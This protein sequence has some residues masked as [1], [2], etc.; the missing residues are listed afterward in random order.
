MNSEQTNPADANLSRQTRGQKSLQDV[1]T[2]RLLLLK[3]L[4]PFILLAV[5][6]FV[7][8]NGL[9]LLFFDLSGQK[10]SFLDFLLL[11]S[12][13][14]LSLSLLLGLFISSRR[15]AALRQI[16]LFVQRF[17][18]GETGAS[19]LI[20]RTDEMEAL[21]N[22]LNQMTAN[23]Q[24]KIETLSSDKA[25][26]VAILSGM[27]EGVMVLD[28]RGEVVLTNASFEKMFGLSSTDL[29][30]RHYYEHLRHHTLNE[31][32]K[33]VIHT[34][35]SLSRAIALEGPPPQYF[36]VQASVADFAPHH[37]VALVFHDITENKRQEQIQKDFVANVSHELRTPISL[38]KGYVETLSDGTVVDPKQAKS[39]LDIIEK[40]STRLENIILDLLQ[41]SRI[42]SGLDPV[43]LRKISLLDCIQKNI[44]LL[45]PLVRKKN[46]R[47]TVSVPTNLQI[48]VDPEKLDQ[49]LTNIID[50]AIKYTPE[51]GEIKIHA[52]E[53]QNNIRIR[54]E[55][56]GIG[57][58]KNEHARIFERFYRVDQTRS[59][60]LGGTG[61]GLAIVKQVV[62]AHG[63][64]VVVQ[65]ERRKGSRFILAFPKISAIEHLNRN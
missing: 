60:E 52:V 13:A 30:G 16:T 36:Q 53:E 26:S 15:S 24:E 34:G 2:F 44:T 10:K 49:V 27:V 64:K 40:N 55:D 28:G 21:A 48:W 22:A 32:I 12:A 6:L 50:N 25:K 63:G 42:E 38:I 1:P 8:M 51:R 46:L 3:S 29:S 61:L 19:T 17:L 37:F 54:I 14:S 4:A 11:S 31:M 45:N 33:E 35:R 5:L 59:R 41:L 39:F 20:H 56:S 43:R 58:P 9:F 65:S 47:L 23:V 18:Q 62:E 57:I 7:L